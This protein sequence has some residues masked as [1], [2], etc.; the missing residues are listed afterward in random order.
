MVLCSDRLSVR[1]LQRRQTDINRKKITAY[2][3]ETEM[4]QQRCNYQR[5]Q[6]TRISNIGTES[7]E[8][9]ADEGSLRGKRRKLPAGVM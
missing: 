1:Q 8:P 3:P 2:D 5:R 9:A 4:C 7:G 6:S